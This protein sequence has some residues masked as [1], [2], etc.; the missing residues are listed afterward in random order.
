MRLVVY[1][2][3]LTLA[4]FINPAFVF[5]GEIKIWADENGVTHIEYQKQRSAYDYEELKQEYIEEIEI[6]IE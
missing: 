5:A 4:L 3:Y 6:Q 1:T 2:L